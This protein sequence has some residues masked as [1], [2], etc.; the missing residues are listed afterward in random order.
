M[1]NSEVMTSEILGGRGEDRESRVRQKRMICEWRVG[2]EGSMEWAARRH[3]KARA[4]F[5]G[6]SVSI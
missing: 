4:Y 2:S 5:S 6:H 1:A 3:R